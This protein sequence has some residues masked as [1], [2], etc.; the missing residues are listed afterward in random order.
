M[1]KLFIQN[2]FKTLD[3]IEK[4]NESKTLTESLDGKKE[5]E[6][7][8]C[9]LDQLQDEYVGVRCAVGEK[10]D[11]KCG[12]IE[13]LVSFNGDF[14]NSIWRFR[15]DEG[16][17]LDCKGS[18]LLNEKLPVDLAKG[19]TFAGQGYNFRRT[20]NS[21][22]VDLYNQADFFPRNMGRRKVRFDFE[23]A[24]YK[25]ISK[26]E[27]LK[28]KDP[29]QRC[30][31]RVLLPYKGMIKLKNQI[32]MMM[33]DE[34]NIPIVKPQNIENFVEGSVNSFKDIINSADKIY[35]T[36]EWEH[37]I[38]REP[39]K[40]RSD[41]DTAIINQHPSGPRYRGTPGSAYKTVHYSELAKLEPDTGSHF[42]ALSKSIDRKKY[43]ECLEKYIEAKKKFEEGTL[44]QEELDEALHLL[45][46][47]QEYI[48]N[49]KAVS[50]KRAEDN[51]PLMNINLARIILL[52]MALDN[53]KQKF[54]KV[55]DSG[56]VSDEIDPYSDYLEELRDL[57][58]KL[59][60]TEEEIK[61]LKLKM[62]PEL[63][64][65]HDEIL[66][67][68]L[69]EIGDGYEE[70]YDMFKKYGGERKPKT[71]KESLEDDE[72][73]TPT[74]DNDI[75]TEKPNSTDNLRIYTINNSG[76]ES[77]VDDNKLVDESQAE[78]RAK[79]LAKDPSY[80]RVV[81]S[82][83]C[84]NPESGDDEVVIL[85]DST[86]DAPLDEDLKPEEEKKPFGE[87]IDDII[88]NESLKESKSFNL[89]N[90]DEI[91]DAVAYKGIGEETDDKFIVVD[92]SIESKDE[93]FKPEPGKALLFCDSCK[94][95]F[96]FP[97][98]ELELDEASGKYNLDLPCPHCGAKEGF[99]YDLQLAAKTDET[100][101]EAE[102]ETD[103]TEEP[104]EEDTLEPV[105]SEFIDLDDI[106]DVKEESFEKLVNPYL[107]KLYENVDN[108][109]TTDIKQ[110]SRNTIKVEGKLTD[111]NGKEQLT[112]FFFKIKE[113]KAGSIVL[114]GYNKLLTE[115]EDAF[116][117]SG[118]INDKSL[119]FESFEY[120]YEK[121][122]NGENV[123]IEGIEK[124]E[125]TKTITE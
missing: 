31:L 76:F 103:T 108:F 95:S 42:N 23:N 71:V 26:E 18:E 115:K 63:K 3:E 118:S 45:K 41:D 40:M 49:D 73:E 123:L 110:T 81:L 30:K 46:E 104:K 56:I 119:I 36:N 105:D 58:R 83:I 70:I 28:Y 121:E 53:Q 82:K 65:K 120:N 2:A 94:K 5:E 9:D 60:E 43:T 102:A 13:K 34:N 7:E 27:A 100:V 89:K 19:Y 84:F 20:K 117:L 92:P 107:T 16:T 21:S 52:K 93:R 17:T 86:A 79:E 111:K 77:F 69:L 109:K 50:R 74:E 57:E 64:D 47:R 116:K 55:D 88:K 38:P 1:D 4:E 12:L 10:G 97:A 72:T 75:K 32:P 15:L 80:E 25:E 91:V 11:R 29:G 8:A 35:L 51:K 67:K 85:F 68:K 96:P 54:Q 6:E 124:A 114:E 39:Q 44:T 61:A 98:D 22:G 112:E 66:E 59:A 87:L 62:T 106:D 99:K 33:W 113:N 14:D 101:A 122:V 24:D 125:D 90:S 78:E 37:E 48:V